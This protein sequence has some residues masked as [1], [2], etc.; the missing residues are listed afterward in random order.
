MN[1]DGRTDVIIGAP[2][3]DPGGLIDAG[4]V[5]VYGLVSTDAP[6][7]K[8]NRP[9]SFE[10]SQNYPNP[11]NPT[12]TIRYFLPKREN[13]TLEIFNLLGER[14]RMLADE[15]QTAGEHT[16]LWDG[17]DEKGKTLSSGIYFYQLKG[18]E[19]SKT[20]KMIFLK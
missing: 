17:K 20:K 2:G 9:E 16:A 10:L 19:F 18:K 12:T 14:V 4:S 11:F 8:N 3:A 13:V 1:G 15:E 6:E 7:E 5:Y